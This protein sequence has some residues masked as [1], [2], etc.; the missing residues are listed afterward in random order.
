MKKVQKIGQK[1]VKS[2]AN[3]YALEMK[4]LFADL[5]KAG[6][7]SYTKKA[8]H[9]NKIGIKTRRNSTWSPQGVKNICLRLESI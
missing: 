5:E 1:A 7:T 6:M 3:A 8:E 9:L 2:N 4:S